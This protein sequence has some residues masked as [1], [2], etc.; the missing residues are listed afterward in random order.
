MVQDLDKGGT[1]FQTAP[2]YMGPSLGWQ[3]A[4]V[5]PSQ[6][7]DGSEVILGG[8]S[9]NP[10]SFG[11]DPTGV[12]DSTAAFN[13]ALA[14]GTYVKFP[15]GRFKF[16]SAINYTTPNPTNPVGGVYK[17]SVLIE[18]A[19]SEN[20]ILD[21]A[22]STDGL[23]INLPT[24][25]S[26]VHIRDLT[27]E[28]NQITAGVGLTLNLLVQFSNGA[29]AKPSDVTNVTF[30]GENATKAWVTNLNLVNVSNITVNTC[31]FSGTGA[32]G[33]GVGI[34]FAG[35]IA[36]ASPAVALMVVNC[37][38][39]SLATSI[40][41]GDWTQ[42]VFIADCTFTGGTLG[43][44]TAVGT[45]PPTG[46]TLDQLNV[47]N[48]QFDVSGTAVLLETLVADVN[49]NNNLI[50]MAG[51]T[52]GVN[53][54]DSLR[55]VIVGNIFQANFGTAVTVTSTQAGS[56]GEIAE[57]TITGPT[58]GI[59]LG[60]GV[61]Y[62][63]V[64]ENIFNAAGTAITNNSTNTHNQI[65]GNP[66]YNPV[67]VTAA[68]NVAAS[69][70]TITAGASPETHYVRQNGTNTATIAKGGQQIATLKEASTY[71]VVQLGPNEAYVVTWTTTTPTF[72]KDVH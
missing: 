29:G 5:Q 58:V 40:L 43:I 8:P 21:F 54:S 61:D 7:A 17:P 46:A 37:Y 19:G 26:S 10:V 23:T 69:P 13:L 56:G 20:T 24:I 62:V 22:N 49:V 14:A 15:P 70:A 71:Y 53:L 68:A 28:T 45:T 52:G 3:K 51:A 66:G 33:S 41:Y 11:A 12:N 34:A 31:W 36:L 64:A 57:N 72:T 35:S 27:I 55:F 2:I 32:S 60:A 25:N 6:K 50:F 18:G 47:T 38:L 30:R 44:H 9:V 65:Y 48:C 39:L 16:L 42:G 59:V 67:G 63:V 4:Q 1:T